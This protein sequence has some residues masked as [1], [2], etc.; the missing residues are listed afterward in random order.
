[1]FRLYKGH[2]DRLYYGRQYLTRE[3]FDDLHRR[4][5]AH[6]CLMLA[7]REGKII[8]GTFNVRD[9]TAM[10]GRYWGCFEEHPFLHFT[11]LRPALLTPSLQPAINRAN[12]LSR[13][14]IARPR[15]KLICKTDSNRMCRPI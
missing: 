2:V 7:E 6:L 12:Q 15:R 10:Y 5:A 11:R 9:N 13:R 14:R 1:M 3:F 4:F 8:A